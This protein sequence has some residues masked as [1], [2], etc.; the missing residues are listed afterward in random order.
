MTWMENTKKNIKKEKKIITE[1]TVNKIIKPKQK[2]S[3]V[4]LDMKDVKIIEQK[5]GKRRAQRYPQK[6]KIKYKEN[7]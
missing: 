4:E 7:R 5:R 3:K 2:G 6:V 1:K